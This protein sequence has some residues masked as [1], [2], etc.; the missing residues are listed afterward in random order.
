MQNKK[1]SMQKE[2]CVKALK[3]ERSKMRMREEKVWGS[4][5]FMPGFLAVSRPEVYERI[6][7]GQY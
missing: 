3:R 4:R 1:M 5:A 7:S 6:V 2:I